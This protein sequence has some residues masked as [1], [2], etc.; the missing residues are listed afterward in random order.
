MSI[1]H[2]EISMQAWQNTR[3]SA[4]ASYTDNKMRRAWLG[5]LSIAFLSTGRAAQTLPSTAQPQT[6]LRLP[7]RIDP[8]HPLTFHE[9]YYPRQSITSGEESTCFVALLVDTDG[10]INAV[11]LLTSTGHP[12]LDGACIASVVN[13]RMLP[14]VINGKPAMRW[15]VNP[16][17]WALSYKKKSSRPSMEGLAIP[18][19][20]VYYELQV[21]PKFYP[22]AAL[23]H[24][25]QGICMIHLLVNARGSI[26]ETKLSKS[27]CFPDLDRACIDAVTLAEFTPAQA[28]GAPPTEAWTDIAMF[29][30]LPK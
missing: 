26:S 30:R 8:K 7:P 1:P 17:S 9:Q 10:Q 20:P 23:E 6:D 11:Q 12:R 28:T 2:R 24:K 4:S 3:N 16:I 22:A 25:E 15:F 19:L 13:E 18:R 5:F 29:W 21:G 14:A 27:T